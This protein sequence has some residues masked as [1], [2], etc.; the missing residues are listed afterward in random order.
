MSN[1]FAIIA[2][3]IAPIIASPQIVNWSK[4]HNGEPYEVMASY[5]AVNGPGVYYAF[6]EATTAESPRKA[7]PQTLTLHLLAVATG[8]PDRLAAEVDLDIY[9]QTYKA[10]GQTLIPDWLQLPWRLGDSLLVHQTQAT[11][12]RSTIYTTHLDYAHY[13]QP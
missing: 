11:T 1:P 9:W 4:Q 2:Q 3:A 7:D 8:I 6:P 12:I 5:A 10:L 13:Q